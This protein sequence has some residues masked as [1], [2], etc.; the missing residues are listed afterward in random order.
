MADDNAAAASPVASGSE[1][2]QEQQQQQQ[3]FLG[4]GTPIP[5]GMTKSAFKKQRRKEAWEAGKADRRAAS[6]EKR[7]AKERS[8][9]EDRAAMSPEQRQ[10]LREASAK[11]RL[12]HINA[13]RQSKGPFGANVVIDCAF[14]ELMTDKEILSICSQLSFCYSS[15]KRSPAPFARLILAGPSKQPAL[16]LLEGNEEGKEYTINPT[17]V[18]DGYKARLDQATKEG[19]SIP[20]AK[21]RLGQAM[22]NIGDKQWRRWKKVDIIEKDGLEALWQEKSE[23]NQEDAAVDGQDEA[24]A[25]VH[26]RREGADA[27]ERQDDDSAA[28][29]SASTSAPRL[30]RPPPHVSR[31]DVIYLTADTG[32]TIHSLDP[33]KTYVIGGLVDRNRYKNLC[34]RKAESLG[35]TAARLPIDAA[36]LPQGKAMSSRKVLTVNQVLDILLGWTEQ[37]QVKTPEGE[38]EKEPSWSE[39]LARGLP[40]R[41][42]HDTTEGGKRKAGDEGGEGEHDEDEEEEEDEDGKANEIQRAE[43]AAAVAQA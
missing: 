33:T 1:S 27:E 2:P 42:F 20:F 3:Q 22:D 25:A 17:A 29:D 10:A 9:K 8:K 35:I 28:P 12:E 43:A 11:E 34:L 18:Q 23:Q 36:F 41:K 13:R 32:H 6:K 15:Q 37:K 16:P 24:A 14:D 7:K 40:G 5:I 31:S 19:K 4:D 30:P 21:S 39:A 38:E 26:E